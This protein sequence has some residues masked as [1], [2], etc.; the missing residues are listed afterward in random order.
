[1]SERERALH[2]DQERE[3]YAY[4]DGELSALRRWRVRRR[5]S[6]DPDARR[7]LEWL[8]ESRA[9]IQEHAAEAS[10]PDL[11]DAI[12]AGLP[13]GSPG[14]AASSSPSTAPVSVVSEG[15]ASWL[16]AWWRW[17]APALAAAAAAVALTFGLQGGDAPDGRSVRWLDPGGRAAMVL[18]DDREATIIWVLDAPNQVSGRADG[19]FS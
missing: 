15:I 11:W 7:E 17:L 9:L 1:M 3:L 5:L 2:T 4:H 14:A 19:A 16:G 18:Q 10:A 13:A 6:R 12:R 8:A